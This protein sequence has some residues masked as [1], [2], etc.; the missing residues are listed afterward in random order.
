[1]SYYEQR[2]DVEKYCHIFYHGKANA[3]SHF[4]SAIELLFIEKGK[5]EVFINGERR[6]LK[7]G[8]GCFC[9]AFHTHAYT[10]D[11]KVLSTTF[12][13]DKSYF[14]R[15]FFLLEQKVPPVFFAFDNFPLLQSLF[16]QWRAAQ[17]N[18]LRTK[19]CF[20]GAAQLLLSEI[21]K[22]T[23]FVTREKDKRMDLIC[24]ILQ[25]AE[26]HLDCDLSLQALS[27]TFNYSREHLSRL[28]HQYLQENWQNY[29]NRLRVKKAARILEEHP[30]EN[31]LNV[32]FSCGFDSANTFY[33]AYKKQ[34]GKSPRKS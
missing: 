14:E 23:P 29:I 20:E 4:H 30:N 27:Q 13:G 33:R 17:D 1:M 9:D 8:E 16:V 31:V 12:I 24:N 21:A 3:I 32:A 11:E 19:L 28:L 18:P 5:Q 34:F 15:A 2:A 26:E 7:A 22:R 6:V 10:Y 25:H